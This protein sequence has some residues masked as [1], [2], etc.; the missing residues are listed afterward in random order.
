MEWH[1]TVFAQSGPLSVHNLFTSCIRRCLVSSD[2]DWVMSA[3]SAVLLIFSYQFSLLFFHILVARQHQHCGVLLVLNFNTQYQ[4]SE[5]DVAENLGMH[6]SCTERTSEGK[7]EMILTVKMET[8]HPVE[9]LFGF[10][11]NFRRSVI[12]AELW[13]PEVARPGNLVSIFACF[14]LKKRPLR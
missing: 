6:V 2:C 11:V 9:G 12:T 5:W 3:L 14:F 13:R 1:N 10:V 4:I 8:R 7:T